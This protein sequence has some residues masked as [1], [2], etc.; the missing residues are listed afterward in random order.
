MSS[1]SRYFVMRR[2]PDVRRSMAFA[3]ICLALGLLSAC[4]DSYD[5]SLGNPRR[6]DAGTCSGDRCDER[7]CKDDGDCDGLRSAPHCDPE[8]HTCEACVISADC[9]NDRVCN[10]A[11]HRCVEVCQKRDDCNDHDRPFCDVAQMAC[12]ECVVDGD[13]NGDCVRGEC[14]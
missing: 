5:L 3:R 12:V 2:R 11:W 4:L 7:S 1:P 14:E 6:L 9:D 8:R 13:C 10:S